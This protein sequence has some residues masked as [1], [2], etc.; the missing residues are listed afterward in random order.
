MK[1]P[2]ISIPKHT[3]SILVFT[4]CLLGFFIPRAGAQTE[5]A[6]WGNINGIRLQGQLME[7]ETSLRVV[8]QDWSQIRA[9]G[10]EQQLPKYRR[11]GDRQIVTTSIDSLFFTQEVEETGPGSARVQLALNSRADTSL[12]GVFFSIALPAAQYAEGS[13]QLIDPKGISFAEVRPNGQQEYLR[14]PAGGVRFI[15]QRRQLEVT[16]NEPTL[17]IVKQEERGGNNAIQVYLPLV[18]GNIKSGQTVQKTFN[19]KVSG[20]VDKTPVALTLNTSQTGRPFAGIG[21]NFRLQNPNTDPQVIDYSLENLRVAWGRVE[22]PWAF[23]QPEKGKDPIA[24]AKA[25]KLH[26]RVEKAME[27]AGRLHKLGMPVILSAWSGPAWAVVGEPKS[28]PGPDGVWGNPLEPANMNEI[29]KSIAD[30]IIY[31]RDNYGVEINMFS[32]NESDL[33]INIRQTG[34]EHRELIKGLGAYF[35]SRGLKTKMLLGDNSDANTYEFIYPAMADPATHPYIGAVSFHSWRGWETETL[36]K[37]DEAADKLN[38]PLIVGEGSID[39]AAWR[40]P[41]IFEEPTYAL[42]EINLYTRILAI[43]EPLTILQWQL[44]ADYSPMTGGGIFGNNEPLR[45]TQRFWN[46]RQLGSTPKGLLAMPISSDSPYITS[47]AMG[48]NAKGTYAIHLVNNGATR[49]VTISGLPRKVKA[50]QIYVTDQGRAMEQGQA[51]RVT[52]GQA[53]FTLDSRSYTTLMSK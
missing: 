46:L 8:G 18:Q 39:A 40:Y 38:I 20:E 1:Y 13:V 52:K 5:M 3:L 44:T 7:F 19:L 15:S 9:T 34:E 6:A 4:I 33:G 2:L 37:W 35:A 29:Y 49:E 41:A 48:N 10:K 14:V 50:L 53:T 42:E 51:I 32:F 31:L 24:A 17:V 43:C 36:Q 30:Y 47:A 26:P 16:F 45:P 23:W 27:M 11:E 28:R 12:T 22:M 21:G 25:G